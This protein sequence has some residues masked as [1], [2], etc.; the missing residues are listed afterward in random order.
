MAIEPIFHYT[1]FE[2]FKGIIETKSIWASDVRYLNDYMEVENG[3]R[4]IRHLIKIFYDEFGRFR[5]STELLRALTQFVDQETTCFAACFCQ[6][7]DQLSQWR[8]YGQS[9][10]GIAVGFDPSRLTTTTGLPLLSVNYDD[11]AGIR[12][13]EQ[14][15]RRIVGH[16]KTKSTR[17]QV[18]QRIEGLLEELFFQMV[19]L[20]NSSFREEMEFRLVAKIE[21]SAVWPVSYRIKGPVFIPYFT[22]DLSKDWENIVREIWIGPDT[23]GDITWHSIREFIGLPRFTRSTP[24]SQRFTVSHVNHHLVLFFTWCYLL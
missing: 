23:L 4:W 12:A 22:L 16:L 8:G 15:V 9:R 10:P 17:T 7:P 5:G 20:K 24:K 6:H 14:A 13:I 18:Q 2:G 3:K 21:N 19:T 11:D 1:N